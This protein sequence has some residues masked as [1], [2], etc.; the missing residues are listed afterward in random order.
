MEQLHESFKDLHQMDQEEFIS[1]MLLALKAEKLHENEQV[2]VL[3]KI[4]T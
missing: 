2:R 4:T 3:F 1:E